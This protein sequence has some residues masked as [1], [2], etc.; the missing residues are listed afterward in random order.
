MSTAQP[1]RSLVLL[2]TFYG[3]MICI[4]GVLGSKLVAFGPFGPVP[5]LGVEAGIFAFILLV[6]ASSAIAETSGKDAANRQVL[7]GFVPL[8]ISMILIRIVL[9][10]PPAP[11][12]GE[13]QRAGFDITLNQTSRMMIAGMIAYAASQTLNVYVFTK[14]KSAPGGFL[15]LRGMI[16]GVLSQVVDT[17]IFITIAFIG[18]AP[19]MEIMPGQ[20]IAKIILSTVLTPP[21]ILGMVAIAKW[22]DRKAA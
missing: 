18:V 20:L 3:G 21:L 17:V 10:L 19:V 7:L 5:A 1:S 16:A 13:E 9:A 4:A 2:S 6:A 8:V 11:F 22:T 15:W 12:W 14:L